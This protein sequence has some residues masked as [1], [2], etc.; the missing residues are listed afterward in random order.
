[1]ACP[2]VVYLLGMDV[3]ESLYRYKVQAYK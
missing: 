1:M 3:V 2:L